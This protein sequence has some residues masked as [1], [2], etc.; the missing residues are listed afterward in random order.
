MYA[1]RS[2][3]TKEY[4]KLI[5]VFQSEESSLFELNFS[6]RIELNYYVNDSLG[7]ICDILLRESEGHDH[8]PELA[9][10]IN[11]NALEVVNLLTGDIVPLSEILDGQEVDSLPAFE[12]PCDNDN[13]SFFA[14]NADGK[15]RLT[16]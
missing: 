7:F 9:D 4:L 1:I 11:Q 8:E 10:T 6:N 5:N 12:P 2:T 13:D 3:E 15:L 14:T 16:L